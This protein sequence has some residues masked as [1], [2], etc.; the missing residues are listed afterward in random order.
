MGSNTDSWNRVLKCL[1]ISIMKCNA[2]ILTAL[3]CGITKWYRRQK[4]KKNVNEIVYN[5]AVILL[6]GVPNSNEILLFL[7]KESYF[8]PWNYLSLIC[9][10]SCKFTKKYKSYKCVHSIWDTNHFIK[11][12][13]C[14]VTQRGL[15]LLCIWLHLTSESHLWSRSVESLSTSSTTS[16]FIKWFVS[17]ILWTHL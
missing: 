2:P 14:I 4:V 17:Q 15:L 13:V 10:S 3:F 9:H 1:I 12:L 6:L 8:S 5:Y 16:L 7:T 11:R